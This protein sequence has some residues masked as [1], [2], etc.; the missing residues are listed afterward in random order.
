MKVRLCG[1]LYRM[2]YPYADGHDGRNDKKMAV[3]KNEA[4]EKCRSPYQI[5]FD[6]IKVL[7]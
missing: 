1:F 7:L 5:V 4:G 6:K 3:K 2:F